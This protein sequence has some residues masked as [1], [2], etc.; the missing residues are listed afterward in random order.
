MQSLP[1]ISPSFMVLERPILQSHAVELESQA[2]VLVWG[3]QNPLDLTA[4][5]AIW[6]TAFQ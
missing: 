2:G 3:E 4:G 1:Q 5:Y 6:W